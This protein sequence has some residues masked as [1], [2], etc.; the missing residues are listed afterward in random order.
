MK[1]SGI[2]WIGEIPN[3]WE[4][5]NLKYILAERKE[6][7]NPI[8]TDYILSLT[9]DRGVI[10]YSEKGN[11]GNKSKDDL[12]QY[13][14]AYP[15]D[16]VL[17]SMNVIVGSV[18]LSKYYGCVSPVYYTLYLRNKEDS[19]KFYNDIFQTKVFQESL[20]GYGN[21]I[22]VKQSEVSGKLNTI[23]MRIPM[24]KLNTVMLPCPSPQEQQKIADYLD[25]KI[26]EI[27]NIITQTTIS[28]KEYKKYK[29]SIITET[30]TKGL[31][32]DVE[33]KESGIEWIGNIPENWSVNRLRD[34][35]YISRGTV[36]KNIKENEIPVTLVQYTNIYNRR[37]QKITDNDYLKIS[38]TDNELLNAKVLKGDILLTASSE[39]A[40]DIGHS[41]VIADELDNYVFGSDI[42]RIRILETI[43]R[44][45]Y[46]KY[47]I[48]NY[49]YLHKLD[50]LCRGITRF[51]FGMDDFKSLKYVLPPIEE[52]EEI[53]VF[54]D[55]KC[56]E[57]DNSIT[58]KQQL[59]T[60]IEAYKKALIYECITGKRE[61]D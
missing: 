36:D 8:K 59:L 14:L 35:A 51:R 4:M 25:E 56:F 39:T 17:N 9:M 21:G 60:E 10:P 12:S 55:K 40:A 15:N 47:F 29:E 11:S 7:N 38:V 33:M 6:K 18:G 42:L 49:V 19:V 45:P 48:E 16:I 41:S 52:Q 26:Y 32:Q 23:R 27:D 44:L 24:I 58:Q 54:L 46:K 53:A 1:D 43:M 61:V 3:D 28:I 20:I 22:M 13:K 5:K 57:I 2:E 50:K 30:V 31:N 34:V 37:E